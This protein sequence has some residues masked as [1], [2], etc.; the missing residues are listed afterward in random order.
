MDS[1]AQPIVSAFLVIYLLLVFGVC[2]FTPGLAMWL[3]VAN[4]EARSVFYVQVLTRIVV[5]MAFVSIAHRLFLSPLFTV[6]G[7]SFA[8]ASAILLLIPWKLHVQAAQRATD[9]LSPLIRYIGAASLV[10]ALTVVA[11]FWRAGAV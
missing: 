6:L 2:M 9:R 4:A 10:L 3:V 5:G 11:S 1:T 7:W 8:I